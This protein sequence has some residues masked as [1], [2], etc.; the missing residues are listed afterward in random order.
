MPLCIDLILICFLILFKRN[1]TE[2]L[3]NYFYRMRFDFHYSVS[4][5][6][7]YKNLILQRIE[8]NQ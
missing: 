2:Y 6:Y 5:S 8:F 7:P 4:I 3:Y 1:V